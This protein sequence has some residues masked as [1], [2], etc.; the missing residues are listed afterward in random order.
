M[1]KNKLTIIHNEDKKWHEK[2]GPDPDLCNF[3]HPFACVMCGPPGCGKTSSAINMLMRQDPPFDELIVVHCDSEYS[4]EWDQCEPTQ[5][6]DHVPDYRNIDGNKKT[7]VM[8]EDFEIKGLGKKDRRLLSRLFGYCVTHKNTSIIA[9][10]QDP[11][12][13]PAV[14]RRMCN[15]FV[16]YPG[17]DIDNTEQYAR[18]MGMPRGLFMRLASKYCRTKYDCVWVDR[19]DGSPAPIR[20]N[21]HKVV[22]QHEGRTVN[23]RNE[24][25]KRKRKASG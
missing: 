2:W 19:T 10:Q 24:T 1:Y 20:I 22:A 14:I 11:V 5:I 16:L 25:N 8:F 6:I 23:E 7:L 9:A 4:Q 17:V 21:C 3:P 18:R 15:I 13:F 12:A